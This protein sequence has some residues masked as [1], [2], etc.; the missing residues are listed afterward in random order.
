MSSA[1]RVCTLVLFSSIVAQPPL[2]PPLDSPQSQPD[3]PQPV[4]TPSPA[5]RGPKFGKTCRIEVVSCVNWIQLSSWVLPGAYEDCEGVSRLVYI[6]ALIPRPMCT[7]RVWSHLAK[8]LYVLSQQ[9][10]F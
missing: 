4:V 1:P 3:K 8:F 2:Q 7:K 5:L 6:V 9:P 10:W